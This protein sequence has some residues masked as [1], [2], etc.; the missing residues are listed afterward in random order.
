MRLD[1]R[2]CGLRRLDEALGE[3]P[4]SCTIS[5][6]AYAVALHSAGRVGDAYDRSQRGAW[7]DIPDDRDS[8]L[9]AINVSRAV[10]D[11]CAALE[12]AE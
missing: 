3:L 12:Y 1:W 11:I 5:S 9:A 8:L 10:G 6:R 4:H 7:R 2:S